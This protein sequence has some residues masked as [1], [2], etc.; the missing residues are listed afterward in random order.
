MREWLDDT[1]A[2]ILKLTPN[3]V[4]EIGCGTGML[5]FRLVTHCSMYW[6]SDI[7]QAV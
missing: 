1:V 7:S 6:A 4:L 3:R 5:L 2:C